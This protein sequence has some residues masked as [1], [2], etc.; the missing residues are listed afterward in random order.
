MEE[1]DVYLRVIHLA[2]LEHILYQR[3][4]LHWIGGVHLL[5]GGEVTG[6]KIQAL[7]TIIPVYR[8][9]NIIIRTKLPFAADAHQHH[10]EQYE[11]YLTH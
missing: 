2:Y 4:G 7:N 5:Q 11:V 8:H 3:A 9:V 1:L 6:C 10:R